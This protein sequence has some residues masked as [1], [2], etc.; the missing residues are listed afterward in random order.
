MRPK[1][2]LSTEGVTLA[3]PVAPLLPKL[4]WCTRLN[5]LNISFILF[6]LLVVFS[7]SALQGN[8]REIDYWASFLRFA[9]AFAHPD[10][11]IWPQVLTALLET[12]EVAVLATFFSII[13]S[14]ILALGAAQSIAPRGLVLILRMLLN[15]VRTIPS[16][17]W[18]LLAV[19]VVGPSPLAGVI[20]LTFYSIGYLGKFYSEAFESVDMDVFHSLRGLGADWLQAFQFGLWPHAKPLIWSHSLWMLEYNIRAASIIGYVGAGGIG[21]QLHIYQEFGAWDR[22]ATVLLF[23]LA[24]VAVLDLLGQ[25]I[26]Q[27]LTKMKP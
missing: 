16:L 7:M 1:N 25:K 11:S 24:V 15:V 2:H 6:L 9:S 3:R 27:E 8:D 18:A 17:I 22:F 10:F 12:L 20:G 19:A 4:P 5:I 26:R 21:L 23:I 13:G 14:F